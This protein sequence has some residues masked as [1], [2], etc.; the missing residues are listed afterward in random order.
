V[1]HDD[2]IDEVDSRIGNIKSSMAMCSMNTSYL[3]TSYYIKV[4]QLL[5]HIKI[6]YITYIFI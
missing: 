5:F 2:H 3:P 6:D 4:K 1:I